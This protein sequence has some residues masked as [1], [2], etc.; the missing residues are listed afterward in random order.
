[1]LFIYLYP[2]HCPLQVYSLTEPPSP[3]PFSSDTLGIPV[4]LG[5]SSPT[6]ARQGS[7]GN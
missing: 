5:T 3:F 2:K 1:M 7:H 4:R 6:E